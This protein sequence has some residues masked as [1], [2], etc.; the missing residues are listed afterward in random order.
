MMEAVVSGRAAAAVVLDKENTFL[1]RADE[2]ENPVALGK[3]DPLAFLGEAADLCYLE[4]VGQSDVVHVLESEV[5]KEEAL[6]LM[7]ILLDGT[8]PDA[9]REEAAEILEEYI[10]NSPE[11]GV[12]NYLENVFFAEPLPASADPTG[13]VERCERTSSQQTKDF[14]NALEKSQPEIREVRD[15]WVQIPHDAFDSLEDR[16]YARSIFAREGL[17]KAVVKKK[18]SGEKIEGLQLNGLF[19]PAIKDV[20]N[21]DEILEKWVEDLPMQE[22]M[23]FPQ[24]R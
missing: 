20:R 24:V 9:L 17:F 1:I 22:R 18:Q 12:L 10:G 6:H 4:D 14:L 13:A 8:N 15:A 23:S 11:S 21:R 16:Q 2:P 7:L 19:T 3:A 5:R